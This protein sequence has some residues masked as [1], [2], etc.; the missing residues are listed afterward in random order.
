MSAMDSARSRRWRGERGRKAQSTV[1]TSTVNTL[2][3]GGGVPGAFRPRSLSQSRKSAARGAIVSKSLSIKRLRCRDGFGGSSRPGDIVARTGSAQR[4]FLK[5]FQKSFHF[6]VAP[7]GFDR[8]I[9]PS[10]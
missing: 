4:Q 5:I 2:W 3:R 10:G 6:V 7:G 9:P 8:L 1:K